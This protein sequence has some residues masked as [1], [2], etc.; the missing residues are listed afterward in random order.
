MDGTRRSEGTKSSEAPH[1]LPNTSSAFE[2]STVVSGFGTSSI[3][4]TVEIGESVF[5]FCKNHIPFK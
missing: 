3:G 1:L 4:M 5:T 2:V